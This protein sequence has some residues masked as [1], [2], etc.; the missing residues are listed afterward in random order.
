MVFGL[1]EGR[2]DIVLPKHE[3]SQGE[4]I[5]GTVKLELKQPK[6]A[7]ELRLVLRAVR[8]R[9]G[10]RRKQVEVLHSSEVVLG[11]EKEYQSKEYPFEVTIPKLGLPKAPE[12]ILGSV[13]GE[14]Q[15]MGFGPGPVRW[16]LSATLDISMSFDISKKMQLNV[17]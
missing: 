1:G 12:G 14:A 8:R 3:F 13:A 9:S 10:R 7:R 2:I 15:A 5:N 11:G 16:Y 17:V 6:K 4:K